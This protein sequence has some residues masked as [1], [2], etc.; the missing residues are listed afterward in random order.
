M[1]DVL[2][3][4]SIYVCAILIWRIPESEQAPDLLQRH[5]QHT[6]VPDELKAFDVRNISPSVR[7]PARPPRASQ[8]SHSSRTIPKA[9]QAEISVYRPEVDQICSKL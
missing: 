4:Q 5:V 6:A 1:L 3:K 2:V 8:G 7:M 9:W